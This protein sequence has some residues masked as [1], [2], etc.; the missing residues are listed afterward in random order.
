MTS[1][2]VFSYEDI[3]MVFGRI[4]RRRIYEWCKK[5]YIIRLIKGYYLFRE[6][7]DVESLGLL[8]SNKLNEPS[9]VSMEYVLSAEG[10]IPESVYSFTAVS[11]NKTSEYDTPLGTFG[12]RN[13]KPGLFTGYTLNRIKIN[14]SGKVLERFVKVACVEKA[15][16]DFLYLNNL[17][18]TDEEITSY[19]FDTGMINQMNKDK[20]FGYADISGKKTITATLKKILKHHALL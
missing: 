7:I 3:N 6:F 12:Y 19:R 11:T 5:G 9:Y 13:I 16:F 20:L 15:F 8:I 1:F 17:K 4:D 18:M 14:L 10:M 2:V